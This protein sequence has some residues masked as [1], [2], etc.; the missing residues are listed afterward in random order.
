MGRGEFDDFVATAESSIDF[1]K[2][3]YDDDEWNEVPP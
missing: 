2:N 1:W 3:P